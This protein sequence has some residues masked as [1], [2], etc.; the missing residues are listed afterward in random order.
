MSQE[1]LYFVP[2]VDGKFIPENPREIVKRKEF[3]PVPYV[4]G[5]NNSEGHGVLSHDLPPEIDE[6]FCKMFIKGSPGI[7]VAVLSLCVPVSNPFIQRF[8]YNHGLI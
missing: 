4:I 5:M 1:N 2:G 6:Q 8:K 7:P 3:N